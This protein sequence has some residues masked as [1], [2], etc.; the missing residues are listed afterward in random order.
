[1][2]KEFVQLRTILEQPIVERKNG[3]DFVLGNIGTKRI[4]LQKCGIGKVNSAV[5]AVEMI[6]NYHPDL[7]VSSGCAGGAAT[8][9]PTA[10][11]SRS[12]DR[13][14]ACPRAMPHPAN[15]LPK[16]RQ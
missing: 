2:D 9:T 7:I 12:S 1:M 4:V 16:P 6:N 3:K 15:W 13:L 14:W 8:T 11:A 5:G 10:A